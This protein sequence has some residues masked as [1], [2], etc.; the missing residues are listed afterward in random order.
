MNTILAFTIGL[1]IGGACGI[2][3][4]ALLEAGRDRPKESQPKEL[5][6]P[7]QDTH[8]GSYTSTSGECWTFT[9]MPKQTTTNHQP[10]EVKEEEK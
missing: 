1:F 3:I 7:L 10:T 9:F 5:V 8:I 2:L 6:I 4:A